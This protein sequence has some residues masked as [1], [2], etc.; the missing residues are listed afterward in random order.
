MNSG[1][2]SPLLLTLMTVMAGIL[3]GMGLFPLP[4]R[5]RSVGLSVVAALRGRSCHDGVYRR[6]Y[7]VVYAASVARASSSKRA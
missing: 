5:R 1:K 7:G 3:V 2:L 4:G 6:R